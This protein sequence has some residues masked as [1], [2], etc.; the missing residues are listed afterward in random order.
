MIYS[1]EYF[2][3]Y[4]SLRRTLH[5]NNV[6]KI[7]TAEL[8]HIE[9]LYDK[10]LFSHY[11][12]VVFL[13]WVSE[14]MANKISFANRVRKLIKKLDIELTD[15]EMRG[16]EGIEP[17][18]FT[19][20]RAFKTIE[21][22]YKDLETSSLLLQPHAYFFYKGIRTYKRRKFFFE[23][24]YEGEIYITIKEVVMYDRI[25][26]KIQQVI[27]HTD[28]N[29]IKLKNE[30]VEIKMRNDDSIYL[31]HKDNE[32]IYISLKRTVTIR[33]G[34]GFVAEQRDELMTTEKTIES[35]LNISTDELSLVDTTKKK[36]KR[37]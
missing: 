30:Y 28:I 32:L 16:I 31:R 37:K 15:Y 26:N 21:V 24:L 33:G 19:E 5:T 6:E 13:R 35:F 36:K 29:A 27:P 2:N 17:R 25:N 8:D 1:M 34:E 23:K 12:K 4:L 9:K 10:E 22:P 20:R 3:L 18:E 11:K 14:N 7:S